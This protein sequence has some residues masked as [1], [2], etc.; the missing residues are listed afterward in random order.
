MQAEFMAA[1][2][3]IIYA[4]TILITY[5]FVIMLASNPILPA[6]RHPA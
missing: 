1:A 4:G 2:L 6:R 5:V 3:V